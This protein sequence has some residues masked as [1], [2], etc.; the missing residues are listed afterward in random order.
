MVKGDALNVVKLL[1]TDSQDWSQVGMLVED[2]KFL[3]NSLAWWS[4][5][6]VNRGA[7]QLVHVLAKKTAV[8]NLNC[9]D[10][11][12]VS[13]CTKHIVFQECL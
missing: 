4:I 2:A 3:L 9:F 10:L 1:Q 5:R 6:Y 8:C 13:F 11:V 12:Y 7:N